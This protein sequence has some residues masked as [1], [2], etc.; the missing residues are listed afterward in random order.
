VRALFNGHAYRV[1]DILSDAVL[2]QAD[3]TV[4]LIEVATNDPLL[5]L[6]V[7]QLEEAAALGYYEGKA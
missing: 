4:Q 6:D 1:V 5:D 7:T 3:D 2:L